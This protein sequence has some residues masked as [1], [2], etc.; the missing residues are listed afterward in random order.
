MR[1]GEV[2]LLKNYDSALDGRAR[3]TPHAA[4]LDPTAPE[5]ARPR[6]SIELRAITFFDA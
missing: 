4:F 2:I 5:W 3:F 6:E 1:P